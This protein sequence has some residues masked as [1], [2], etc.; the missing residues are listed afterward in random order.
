MLCR[1]LKIANINVKNHCKHNVINTKRFNLTIYYQI[2]PISRNSMPKNRIAV[3]FAVLR[4]S[5]ARGL[6][7]SRWKDPRLKL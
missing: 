2:Q 6:A 5:Q 7:F 3:S 4:R 1:Q